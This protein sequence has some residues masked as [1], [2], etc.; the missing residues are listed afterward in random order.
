MRKSLGQETAAPHT[1]VLTEKVEFKP[2]L[3]YFLPVKL[4]NQVNGTLQAFPLPGHGSGDLAN[5]NDADAFLELP[6]GQD[7][8]LSGEIFPLLQYRK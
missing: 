8:F 7:V 1:A 2:R 4:D 5:L 6:L 3:T